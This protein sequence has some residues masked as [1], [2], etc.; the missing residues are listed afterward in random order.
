MKKIEKAV[1]T[2]ALTPYGKTITIKNIKKTDDMVI[3]YYDNNNVINAA[4]LREEKTKKYLDEVYD[5]S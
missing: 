1:S 5:F 3:A 4:I 2:K